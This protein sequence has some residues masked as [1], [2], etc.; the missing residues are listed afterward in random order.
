MLLF[1]KFYKNVKNTGAVNLTDVKQ[2]TQSQTFIAIYN[3]LETQG[4]LSE[5]KVFDTAKELLQSE[6]ESQRLIDRETYFNN[7]SSKTTTNPGLVTNFSDAQK[8]NIRN[9]FKNE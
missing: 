5:E 6:F 4:A 8:L 7:A 9:I 3:K 1:R 2:K